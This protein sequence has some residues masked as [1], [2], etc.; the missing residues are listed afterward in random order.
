V[1]G[2]RPGDLMGDQGAVHAQ[3]VGDEASNVR[4]GVG[5]PGAPPVLAVVPR[6]E[7]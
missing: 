3:K 4:G 6:I 5:G 7:R 1:A 2:K